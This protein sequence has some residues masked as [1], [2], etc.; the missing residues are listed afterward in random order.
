METFDIKMFA[1]QLR[2][3]PYTFPGCYP[4]YFITNDGCAL[5]FNCAHKERHLIYDSIRSNANDGWRV[6]GADINYED[7]NLYCEHCN[8]EIECA[9]GD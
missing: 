4:V 2:L 7:N 3:G 1:R 6:M 5:C 9:Y 8:K